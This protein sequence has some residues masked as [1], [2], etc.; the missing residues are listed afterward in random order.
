MSLAGAV[1]SNGRDARTVP[2][3][4]LRPDCEYDRIGITSTGL[5][6]LKAFTPQTHW[7]PIDYVRAMAVSLRASH[8]ARSDSTE[9]AIINNPS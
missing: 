3:P 4:P 5:L 2:S 9:S 7:S 1:T 6:F 8:T